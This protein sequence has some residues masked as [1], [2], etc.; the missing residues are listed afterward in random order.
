MKKEHAELIITLY[1]AWMQYRRSLKIFRGRANIPPELTESIVC[2]TLGY[3]LVGSGHRGDATDRQDS[4]IEIKATSIEGDLTSFSPKGQYWKKI[5]F[6][7]VYDKDDT[8]EIKIYDLS[9]IDFNKI[10][11]NKRE[12]F[13]E[14]ADNDR[15][16]RF[17]IKNQIIKE[18]KLKPIKRFKIREIEK[19]Y[20]KF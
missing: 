20:K 3:K 15:R 18:R 5:Y 13:K 16:P 4:V 19:H 7:D 6:V 8:E 14:Q 12:T 9:K 2:Y 10:S 11:V 1:D 17:S